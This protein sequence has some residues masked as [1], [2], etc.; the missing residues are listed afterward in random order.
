MNG[1]DLSLGGK[2]PHYACIMT[3]NRFIE[4][5][6]NGDRLLEIKL[7]RATGKRQD[8]DFI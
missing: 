1:C 8:N 4:N 2:C 5:S 3:P 6:S 7:H